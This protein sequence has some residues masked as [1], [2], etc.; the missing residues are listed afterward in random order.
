[1]FLP[2]SVIS[3]WWSHVTVVVQ[4]VAALLFFIFYFLFFIIYHYYKSPS[5][6]VQ[7]DPGM[8][9]PIYL[10]FTLPFFL[11]ITNTKYFWKLY[12]T[13]NFYQSI[14]LKFNF[15]FFYHYYYFF[16]LV[17]QTLKVYNIIHPVKIWGY[18]RP[19]MSK[20]TLYPYKIYKII[21][22]IISF[23]KNLWYFFSRLPLRFNFSKLNILN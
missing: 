7:N 5:S 2:A 8:G 6:V 20:M 22:I 18:I 10:T 11:S 19:Q 15:I 4:L 12:L 21:L 9:N 23:L 17:Y 16:N 14:F 13:P 3:K 1:M